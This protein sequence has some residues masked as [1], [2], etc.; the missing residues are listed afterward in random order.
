MNKPSKDTKRALAAVKEICD[1]RD[2]RS[3]TSVLVTTEHAVA[4]LLLAM[5]PDPAKA[6]AML[7]EGLLPGIETRLS[8]RKSQL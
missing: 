8:L 7:H 4:T 6:N 1:G 5:F 3:D 2:P